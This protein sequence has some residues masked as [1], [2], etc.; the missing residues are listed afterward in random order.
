M[1]FRVRH[2]V[3][4]LAALA[5]IELPGTV[6]AAAVSDT[7]ALAMTQPQEQIVASDIAPERL[8][9]L[10]EPI[11]VGLNTAASQYEA[12]D[13]SGSAVSSLLCHPLGHLKPDRTIPT[14]T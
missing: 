6:P 11:F 1:S 13:S 8:K 5:F 2:P 14:K 3:R 4:I 12:A 10:T 9:S 7:L